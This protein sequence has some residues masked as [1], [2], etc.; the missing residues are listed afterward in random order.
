MTAAY[1]APIRIVSTASV[2]LHDA[3]GN[4]MRKALKKLTK[5]N[6]T[7]LK[8]AKNKH[9]A[10]A[11]AYTHI[12]VGRKREI[13]RRSDFFK[14]MHVAKPDTQQVA[15]M[16]MMRLGFRSGEVVVARHK[17]VDI[18]YSDMRKSVIYVFDVKKKHYQ[19]LPMTRDLITAYR[20]LKDRDGFILKRTHHYKAYAGKPL[21]RMALGKM[22]KKWARKAGVRDW[23]SYYPL[24]FRAF[25]AKEW[26][27]PHVT[28]DGKVSHGTVVTL[29]ELMRHRD[30]AVTWRYLQQYVYVE[31]LAAEMQRLY[32]SPK[33]MRKLEDIEKW[34]NLRGSQF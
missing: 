27:R 13:L 24:R 29:S 25:F 8:L 31:D 22:V 21:S 5:I 11:R 10:S 34:R 23:R 6:N 28:A 16:L 32:E 9:V 19:P 1:I 33:T 2:T 26:V 14:I 15:C 20:R 30:P 12:G 7:F 4:T 17:D 18:N 3:Q